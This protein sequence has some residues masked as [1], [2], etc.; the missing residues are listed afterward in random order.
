MCHHMN[1]WQKLE[2]FATTRP[3]GLSKKI[4]LRALATDALYVIFFLMFR[5]FFF[6]LKKKKTTKTHSHQ[7]PYI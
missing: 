7:I 1:G 6:F 3:K 4:Y 5:E 2:F